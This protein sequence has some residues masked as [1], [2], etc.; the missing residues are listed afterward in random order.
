MGGAAILV[1]GLVVVLLLALGGSAGKNVKSTAV[2]R[3]QALA[4]LAANGTTTVSSAAPGLFALVTTGKLST[5]VPAGWRATAQAGS[6][7]TRAEFADPKHP[8]STLTIVAQSG[9][10]GGGN[11]HNRAGA[12]ERAV[13]SKGYTVSSYGPITFPGGREAWHLTYTDP[14]STHET[15]FYSACKGSAAMVVDIAASSSAFQRAQPLL[16]ATAASAEPLC[17]S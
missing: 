16:E 10:G 17:R 13:R 12:A 7:T 9:G 2:T 6:G 1:A 15:Y 5:I 8:G 4:L 11:D 14:T 3:E